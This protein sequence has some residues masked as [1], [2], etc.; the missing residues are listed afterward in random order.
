MNMNQHPANAVEMFNELVRLGYI[1]PSDLE[2]S[3]LHTP[4]AYISVPTTLAFATA[5]VAIEGTGSAKNAKLVARPKR[6]KKRKK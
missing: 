4:T 3:E 6:N 2:P 5:P 1:V